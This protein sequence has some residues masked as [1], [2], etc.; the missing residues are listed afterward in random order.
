MQVSKDD[1]HLSYPLK[2]LPS[3][4]PLKR[5]AS[6]RIF[7]QNSISISNF[8]SLSSIR[9][10]S[11]KISILLLLSIYGIC[12]IFPANNLIVL[13]VGNCCCK[14]RE[15]QFTQLQTMDFPK[16]SKVISVGGSSLKWSK[17]IENRLKKANEVRP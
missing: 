9:Y 11:M 2:V 12:I 14:E 1:D 15:I 10:M 17:P 7:V 4:F 13:S 5:I 6:W 16:K 8:S 3:L